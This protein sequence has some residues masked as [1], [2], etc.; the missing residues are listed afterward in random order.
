MI[1]V[2]SISART[3]LGSGP[4]D[5]TWPYSRKLPANSL[6]HTDKEVVAEKL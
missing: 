3:S 2:P 4:I 5:F 6:N 1:L